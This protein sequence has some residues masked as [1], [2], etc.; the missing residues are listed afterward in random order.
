MLKN[1]EMFLSYKPAIIKYL[2]ELYLKK[3]DSAN[4]TACANSVVCQTPHTE[5]TV[6]GRP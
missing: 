1:K 5:I 6:T 2:K 3:V 4:R